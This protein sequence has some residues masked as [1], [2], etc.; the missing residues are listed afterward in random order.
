MFDM[1][2]SYRPKVE[3]VNSLHDK[4]HLSP[5]VSEDNWL[6][7]FREKFNHVELYKQIQEAEEEYVILD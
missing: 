4:I 3:P 2:K 1:F 6:S 7:N 5:I